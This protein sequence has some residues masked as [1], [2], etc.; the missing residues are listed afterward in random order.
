MLS[1]TFRLPP[2]LVP[3][4]AL[5][6]CYAEQEALFFQLYSVQEL[7]E[8]IL[9]ERAQRRLKVGAVFYSY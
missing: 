8:Q 2:L 9:D 6:F 5:R 4:L 7:I 3:L 1:F